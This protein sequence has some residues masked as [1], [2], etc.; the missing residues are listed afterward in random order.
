MSIKESIKS[1]VSAKNPLAVARRNRM[2]AQ[3]TNTTMT[4]LCPNCLGGILFHDLGLQFRSPTVNLMMEQQDFVRFVLHMDEYLA[5]DFEFFDHPEYSFPCA[6][7]G[8]ITVHFTHFKTKEDALAKW[9]AR[10]ARIDRSNMFIFALERDA[11]T[12]E[13]IAALGN[14]SVRGIA[15]FTAHEYP[16]LPYTIYLPELSKD[17]RIE[18]NVLQKSYKDDSRLYEKYFDF[19]RWF[20]EANGGNYDISPFVK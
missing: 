10:S 3:M 17:G 18:A 12:Y 8:D 19:V 4:F 1:L 14:L 13:D 16:N 6:H 2:R 15:V 20:N 9:Q 11:L 7:L 5:K